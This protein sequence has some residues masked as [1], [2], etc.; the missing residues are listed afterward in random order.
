MRRIAAQ[1]LERLA[2]GFAALSFGSAMG[3]AA[4][5]LLGPAAVEPALEFIA[6]A[7]A[8]IAFG[9][10][11]FVLAR[12]E[13]ATAAL[14]PPR[15][16]TIEDSPGVEHLF[17]GGADAPARGGQSDASAQLR[18]AFDQLRRSLR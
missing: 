1:R 3:W 8:A 10:S 7:A 9:G 4:L 5:R 16:Q 11:L 18:D 15:L 12:I 14:A 2:D 13:P 6:L 17:G